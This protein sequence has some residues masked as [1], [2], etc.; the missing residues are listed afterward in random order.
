MRGPIRSDALCKEIIRFLAKR[1]KI[2]PKLI[3]TKLMSEDD[4]NDL[5]DGNLSEN[6]FSKHIE[7]W[8][9]KGCPDYRNGEIKR[10]PKKAPDSAL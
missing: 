9:K 6:V 5:R 1:H 8:I 4:K 7:V 10:E 3:V 2:D